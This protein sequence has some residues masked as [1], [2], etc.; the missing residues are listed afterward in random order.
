M[1]AT[2]FHDGLFGDVI[3]RPDGR[4]IHNMYL[5]R[6]RNPQQS[7]GSNDIEELVETLTGEQ[8]FRPIDQ[9]GCNLDQMR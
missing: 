2:T 3:V 8:A 1:K 7:K 6:V 5:L 4:A 9:G